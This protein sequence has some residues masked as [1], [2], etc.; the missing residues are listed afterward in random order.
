MVR[1]VVGATGPEAE[2]VADDYID[3]C[4]GSRYAS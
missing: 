4:P 2:M 1:T 3:I